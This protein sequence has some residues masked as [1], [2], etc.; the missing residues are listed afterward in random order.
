MKEKISIKNFSIIK[1]IEFQI[2][3]F[4]LI[5]GE[6]ASGKSLIAKTIYF[7]KEL[8]PQELIQSITNNQNFDLYQSKI[9]EVFKSLFP[10]Y[11]WENQKFEIKFNYKFEDTWIK[12]V[13]KNDSKIPLIDIVFA[14]R[15]ERKFKEIK[16]KFLGVPLQISQGRQIFMEV[17]KTFNS[18]FTLFTPAGRSFFSLI[19]E[20]I[21]TLSL[22]G[23]A[24]D[25]FITQ[26]GSYYEKFKKNELDETLKSFATKILKGELYYDKK[27]NEVFIYGE[28]KSKLKDSSTGQQELVPIF[29]LL[30]AIIKEKEFS[31]FLII[32][33]PGAHL[34]PRTQKDLMEFFAYVSN[35][36]NKKTGFLFT[37]HSPYIL[38]AVSNLVQARN[39]AK[40]KPSMIK[41]I[42]EIIK[43]KFWLDIDDVSL[44]YLSNGK[45]KSLNDDELKNIDAEIIDE[46]SEELSETF[47]KLL[48]IKYSDN[49]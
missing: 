35:Y 14:D 47:D 19:K 29:M 18:E 46:V 32:E 34:F 40:E 6:Q 21:F 33:E 23:V 36:T 5:I 3:E 17:N 10:D 13:K 1:D 4:N 45:I 11:F 26:F 43:D 42:N 30:N 49:D 15:I 27:Q 2:N 12:I 22:M 41:E 28:Q 25:F 7:F 44:F 37:T 31:H 16:N 20:N 9:K 48:N 39:T 24:N 38:T 8:I